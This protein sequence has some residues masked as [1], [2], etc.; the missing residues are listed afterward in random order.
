MFAPK[1]AA[2]T[3][4][5]DFI[6]LIRYAPSL[7]E[8][9]GGR[10]IIAA[11]QHSL[12]NLCAT[13]DGIDAVV[14]TD[15]EHWRTLRFEARIPAP[16][17]RVALGCTDLIVS[18]VPYVSVGEDIRHYWRARIDAAHPFKVGIGIVFAASN[19]PWGR[20]RSL[21]PEMLRPLAR[22][23]GVCLFNLQPRPFLDLGDKYWGT[24]LHRHG[25]RSDYDGSG[26]GN[27][28]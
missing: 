17:L 23:P 8:A 24:G 21:D 12:A 22:I 20:E 19:T 5:G 13:V 18:E 9:S 3:G 7:K 2:D 14:A 15:D 28:D 4:L 26:F 11:C 16:S 25:Y 1:E 6:Q 10:E 27:N